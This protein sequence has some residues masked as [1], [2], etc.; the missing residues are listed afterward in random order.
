MEEIKVEW[1]KISAT[2]PIVNTTEQIELYKNLI[3]E[4]SRTAPIVIDSNNEII[5]GEAKYLA[6]EE[7]GIE[8]IE[9]VRIEN[10]TENQIK[11]L[12]IAETKAIQLGEWDHE[13]L[14]KEL[15]SIG[16]L[17]DISGFDFESVKD[18]V[19]SLG[20]S[21]EEV[22]E[23]D[24]PELEE[25][26][27]TKPGDLFILGN[28]RLLCGDSTKEEDVKRLMQGE[29]ADLMITDPP[30]NV[31]YQG[32]NGLKIKNDNMDRINFYK[33]LLDFYKN[34]LNH[35]KEGASYYIFH[36]DLEAVSFRKALEESGFKLSQI[37][38]WIK[39]SF[40]LS[41]QDY[42]WKHEPII[43][44]WKPGASHFFIKDY[45]QD[46][47]IQSEE[48]LKKMSKNELI[49]LILEIKKNIEESSTIIREDRPSRNDVHPTMKPIKLLAR[50]MVNSSKK[51]Q[52]V[53]D[54]FGG[55]GS[56]LITAEQVDRV[57]RLMEY[58]PRYVD[59]I[60][61]RYMKMD[62]TD[63]KL[64]RDGEEI[65]YEIIKDFLGD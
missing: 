28:H 30:Y 48:K 18:I 27:Y 14:F 24:A 2:S 23:I 29:I 52:I 19:E 61:K 4:A 15:E 17:A 49:N 3:K 20:D 45:T 51:K 32:S 59:V 57:A 54:L 16:D 8:V 12:R 1:L 22:K 5:I 34:A 10:I 21:I 26:P 25:E 58:D 63:I 9:V 55:S 38:V 35:M 64:I 36:A 41:R 40:S 50:L 53:I 31:N 42:N 56:T 6:Y 62:K 46:T 43:Y 13:K 60:V 65:S 11:L 33:F 7:L 44:G 37:L 47:E 39:N